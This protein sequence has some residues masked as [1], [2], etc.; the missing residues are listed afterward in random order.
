MEN[1]IQLLTSENEKLSQS[2]LEKIKETEGFRL[3]LV[4]LEERLRN[5]TS[6]LRLQLEELKANNYVIILFSFQIRSYK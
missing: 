4:Q 6:E 2:N 5:E 3:K 1:Q